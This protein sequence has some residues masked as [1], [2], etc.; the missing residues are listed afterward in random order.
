MQEE[1][2]RKGIDQNH[3]KKE[4]INH[5][6]IGKIMREDWLIS[7]RNHSRVWVKKAENRIIRIDK[8]KFEKKRTEKMIIFIHIELDI[9]NL[10]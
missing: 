7:D 9:L 4:I 5:K 2:V 10:I 3:L 1:S 6:K 8:D